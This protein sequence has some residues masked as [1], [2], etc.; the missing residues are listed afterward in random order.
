MSIYECIFLEGVFFTL[1]EYNE[2]NKYNECPSQSLQMDDCVRSREKGFNSQYKNE[3]YNIYF[4][5][6]CVLCR[7]FLPV[8]Q[9][10]TLYGCTHKHFP[11]FAKWSSFW[12]KWKATVF[13]E[14]FWCIYAQFPQA[15]IRPSTISHFSLLPVF[16]YQSVTNL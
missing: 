11:L 12:N 9:S 13:V 15:Q 10:Y 3:L 8:S 4:T 2:Y 16:W 14:F 1:N 6:V 7:F 5:L